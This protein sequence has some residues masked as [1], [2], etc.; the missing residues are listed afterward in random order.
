[1]E[2]LYSFR[3]HYFEHNAIEKAGQKEEDVKREMHKTFDEV[4]KYKGNIMKT[5]PCKIQRFFSAVKK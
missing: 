4:Q 2:R 5:C 3:D 1:M